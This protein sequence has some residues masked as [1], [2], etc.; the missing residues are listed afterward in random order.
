MPLV[1]I[2]MIKG[3]PEKIRK[4]ILDAVHV[5]LVSAFKIPDTDRNQRIIE[6]DAENFEYPQGK[7]DCFITIEMT[8]FPGRS[9]EAKRMLYKDIVTRLEA[10]GIPPED[11]L[12]VLN[13]PPL[14]N[15]GIRGGYP[16]NEVDIGFD[17][18]V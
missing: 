15:W 6:I 9:V 5:S 18:H 1:T 8:V 10:I 4:S 13:D 14:Q 17:L 2:T 7:S 11:I 16:A 12:I 3:K